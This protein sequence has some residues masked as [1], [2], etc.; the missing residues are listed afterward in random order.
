MT[1]KPNVHVSFELD[2]RKYSF[3]ARDFTGEDDLLLY[4]KTGCTVMD[5]FGGKFT[6]FTLAGLLWL[7]R[8]RTEPKLTFE[9]VNRSMTFDAL[10]TISDDEDGD[11]PEA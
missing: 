2:G 11:L 4:Q 9:Q 8:R 3:A 7:H 10:E 5:V 6:L 1:D